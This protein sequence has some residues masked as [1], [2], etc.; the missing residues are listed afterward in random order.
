M[1]HHSI[2]KHTIISLFLPNL[3]LLELP[4]AKDWKADV[5]YYVVN[6]MQRRKGPIEPMGNKLTD[7][8]IKFLQTS[9]ETNP[10]IMTSMDASE[11]G[12]DADKFAAIAELVAAH[13]P[14]DSADFS[15]NPIGADGGEALGLM[16]TADA[17]E[18]LYYR[19]CELGDEGVAAFAKIVLGKRSDQLTNLYIGGNGIGPMDAAA[20]TEM[21]STNSRVEAVELADNPIGDEGLEALLKYIGSTRNLKQLSLTSCGIT[22][23]GAIKLAEALSGHSDSGLEF[24]KLAGNSIGDEGAVAIAEAIPSQ[25]YLSVLNVSNCGMTDTGVQALIDARETSACA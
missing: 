20:L 6:A 11:C 2:K 10:R 7:E 4:Q 16:V 25:T 5:T 17:V 13:G 21:L 23:E 14:V 18:S 22:S 15:D 8:D 12:L 9:F 3:M 1:A 19:D 24:L